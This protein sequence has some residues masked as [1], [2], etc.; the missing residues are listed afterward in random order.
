MNASGPIPTFASHC[1]GHFA[2]VGIEG[3]LENTYLVELGFDVRL[4][5]RGQ[6]GSERQIRSTSSELLIFAVALAVSTS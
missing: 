5:T 3:P 2:N 1:S 6:E 4:R